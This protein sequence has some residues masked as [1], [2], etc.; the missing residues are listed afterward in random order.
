MNSS[1]LVVKVLQCEMCKGSILVNSSQCDR[2][3]SQYL[4]PCSQL[5]VDSDC[6]SDEIQEASS[7]EL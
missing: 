5:C 6:V 7:Y 3:N 2:W 4:I 1:F